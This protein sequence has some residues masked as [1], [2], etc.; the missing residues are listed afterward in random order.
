[1]ED[2]VKI[3]EGTVVR[4]VAGRDEGRFFAVTKICGEQYVLIADGKTRKLAAPKKKNI[5]HLKVTGTVIEITEITDK[6]LKMKLRAFGSSDDE[7][8]V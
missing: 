8:E 7:S 4:A 1:M 5:K 2:I 6:K 3:V